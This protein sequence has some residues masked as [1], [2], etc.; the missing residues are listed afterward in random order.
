M[1]LDKDLSKF[2]SDFQAKHYPPYSSLTPIELRHWFNDMYAK[3]DKPDPIAVDRVIERRVPSLAG[4]IKIRIYYP[5]GDGPFPALSYFHG[6]GFV[7]RDQMDA[8]EQTC[9]MICHGAHCAVIAVDFRLAP[10]HPFPASPEDCYTA[11]CWVAD[12]ATELNIDKKRIGTWGESCGGNLATV[13]AMMARDRQAPKLICQV[14]VTAMLDF[15]FNTESYIEN[16][17]GEYFLSEDSMRW[18]WNHYITKD[19][20][21]KNPYCAPSQAT[22]LKDLPPALVVTVEYD[23]LRDEGENYAQQLEAAG[24]KV[25]YQSYPGLIH[26]F[27][28]LYNLSP[29]ADK[30]CKEI[31]KTAKQML[32]NS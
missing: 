4:E 24:V 22:N 21:K 29:A 10:E 23:P 19:A 30:A 9:R 3:K 5:E 8:Y 15:N 7:F 12:H 31:I 14:I 17:R 25:N 6:G 16:G 32:A 28:D 18:F 2:L 26:T 27:F 20:D 1:A 13:V 11:I